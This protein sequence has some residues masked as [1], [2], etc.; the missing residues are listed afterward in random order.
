MGLRQLSVP[1]D[2]ILPAFQ[3]GGRFSPWHDVAQVLPRGVQVVEV[4]LGTW[5]VIYLLSHKSWGG[6]DEYGEENEGGFVGIPRLLLCSRRV[7][8]CH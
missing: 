7:A 1:H 6:P 8:E 5:E 2:V 4:R 3:K